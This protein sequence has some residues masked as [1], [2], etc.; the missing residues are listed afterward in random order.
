VDDV[1]EGEPPPLSAEHPMTA[2]V[3]A[4][5]T[6]TTVKPPNLIIR[7]LNSPVASTRSRAPEVLDRPCEAHAAAET[8]YDPRYM[9]PQ[10]FNI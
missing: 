1:E 2:E 10:T 7:M 6:A 4:S 8:A 5:T 3:D 9:C